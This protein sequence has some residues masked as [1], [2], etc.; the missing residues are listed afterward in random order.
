MISPTIDIIVP[1]WNNPFETRA[2]IAAILVHSPGARLVVV[3]NGGSR[4]TELMLEEFSESLGNKALFI[5]SEKNVGQVAAINLGLARSDS[6]YAV[7]VLPQV[8]VR[9]GWLET[10]VRV[11]ETTGAGLVSPMFSGT[12]APELPGLAPG[13]TM[14]ESCRVTFSTL[15][16]RREMRMVAGNF[17]ED[18]DGNE[19][20]LAEYVRRVA[21]RGYRTCITDRLRL[22]CSAGQ[23]YGSAQRRNEMIQ[24]SRSVYLS[25]W[26]ISRHYC[27]YFGPK[28]DAASLGET[29]AAILDG[30]RQG[31]RFTLLLHRRQNSVFRKS[32]WNGLHSGIELYKLSFLFT[33]R[34]LVR[35]I[36]RLRGDSPGLLPVRGSS[37]INFPGNEAAVPLDELLSYI[38]SQTTTVAVHTEELQP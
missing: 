10:L 38:G 16:M 32:G 2:C 22:P 30:A 6:C 12:G 36:E 27:V 21:A 26:G 14:T 28:I 35:K 5:K 3:D 19:W 37:E 9:A 24:H 15:L 7:I 33:S 18:L 29:I 23:L 13:C 31:H 20:C 4:E 11:A 17:D 1:V 8:T 34:D 25:R